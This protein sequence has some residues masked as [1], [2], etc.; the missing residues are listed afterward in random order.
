RRSQERMMSARP[1][2]R[3][4]QQ[5]LRSLAA[6]ANPDAHPLLAERGAE[7]IEVVVMTADRGLCGSFNTNNPKPSQPLLLAHGARPRAVHCV[8]KKGRDFFRRRRIPIAREYVD[9]FRNVDAGQAAEIARDLIARFTGNELDAVYLIYNEFKSVIQQ[10]VIV[11]R[12]IP[13][14]RH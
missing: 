6:R 3:L 1:Y 14:E 9:V 4:M 13:I 8:G 5:V 7:R 12:L 10:R 2:S 11:D